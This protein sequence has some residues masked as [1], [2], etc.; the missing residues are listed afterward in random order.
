MLVD[1]QKVVRLV[2]FKSTDLLSL[3]LVSKGE[4]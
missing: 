4:R 2:R 1:Y 3:M